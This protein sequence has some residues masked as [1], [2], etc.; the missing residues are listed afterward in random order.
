MG[1]SRRNT[2]RRLAFFLQQSMEVGMDPALVPFDLE[3]MFLG[4]H[5]LLYS[6]EIVF[7]TAVI[8]VYALL[9]LRWLGSRTI[10]Q[11]STVEFLLVI[12]LGSAV[13]DAMFYP[14]VPLLHSL[15]VVTVVVLANKALDMLIARSKRAECLIDGTPELLVIDGVLCDHFR[16][17]DSMGMS[18]LFQQLRRRGIEHLGQVRYAFAEP[19]GEV[20][21]YR[22]AEPDITPGLPIVPPW[23]LQ[24]PPEMSSDTRLPEHQ[25]LACLRCGTRTDVAANTAPGSCPNCGHGRWTPAATD[26][27][28]WQF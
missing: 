21:A 12:A 5:P 15:V 13:G 23:E 16:R 18:E 26:A 6:I 9:L 8:Y 4:E 20:T 14:E 10:G 19:D 22:H 28:P 1:L 11:L 27:L 2:G 25:L 17:G 24:P 7:R 3:R